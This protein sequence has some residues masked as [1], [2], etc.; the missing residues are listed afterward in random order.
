MYDLYK[1]IP[2][3]EYARLHEI[4][5]NTSLYVEVVIKRAKTANKTFVLFIATYFGPK[6]MSTG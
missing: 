5:E 4:E 6:W 1:V 2:H 3:T